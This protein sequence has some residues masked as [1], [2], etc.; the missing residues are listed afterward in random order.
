MTW[1]E[2][3][4]GKI[5]RS[6]KTEDSP[7][8]VGQLAHGI[9]LFLLN[10]INLFF[11]VLVSAVFNLLGEVFP[12]LCFFFLL[13]FFTGGVHFKNPWSCLV[14]TL[15]LLLIGGAIIKYVSLASVAVM[16]LLIL[17][18]AGAGTF[19]NYTYAPAKHTYMPDNPTVQ[20][21]HRKIAILLI[22]IGCILSLFLVRYSYKLPMTYILAIIYQSLLLMPVSFRFVSFLEKTFSRG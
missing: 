14:A 13:R 18:V 10:V 2:K 8:T 1:T 21:K 4:S 7:Y 9:E 19:I 16:P 22:V 5:A 17:L 15:L 20:K 3:L 6:I 12:L 11:I